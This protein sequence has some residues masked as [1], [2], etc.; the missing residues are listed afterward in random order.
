MSVDRSG[1]LFR[2]FEIAPGTYYRLPAEMREDYTIYMDS[3]GYPEETEIYF[4][5]EVFNCDSD[6]SAIDIDIPCTFDIMSIDREI[7]NAASK[8]GI[9]IQSIE[10]KWYLGVRVC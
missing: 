4:G 2:G 3:Y 8:C 7:L 5:I 9:N 10:C 1:I 6:G